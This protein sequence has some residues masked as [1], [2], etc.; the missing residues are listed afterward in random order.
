MLH[1]KRAIIL[2]LLLITAVVAKAQPDKVNAAIGLL[3]KGNLD[4]AKIYIDAAV[5]DPVTADNGQVWY[6]RGFI[7]KS[8]YKE[9]EKDNRK[10]PIRLEALNSF[11]KSLFLDTTQENVQNNQ[12]NIKFLASTLFN[13]AGASLDSVNYKVAIEDFD[14]Y[15]QYYV[16]V[17]P[18]PTNLK[19][20]EID[21]TMAIATVYY[22]IYQGDR[23]GKLDFLTF[24]KNAY[25]KVLTLDPNNISANY[26][27]GTLYYN[28]AVNLIKQSDYTIDIVA[29]NDVQDNSIKLFKESLPFMEKAYDLD[30]TRP[31]TL[32]GLSGIYFSLN[33]KEKSDMFKKKLDEINKH[34]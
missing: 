28:Q 21:F 13:D 29:L 4:S 24:T 8:I 26:N 18:S 12:N 10:S 15:K 23:A 22:E 6:Y 17:D 20:K 27:M 7:Y 14:V 1:F 30:P 11:K 34:K 32:L 33:D 19:Q 3:Q 2:M 16:L 5:K 9:R 25:N 31:E